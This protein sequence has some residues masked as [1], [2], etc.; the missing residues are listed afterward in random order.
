MLMIEL[1]NME[2]LK[3]MKQNT[4][5]QALLERASGV[6]IMLKQ[7]TTIEEVRELLVQYI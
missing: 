3:F 4:Y 5:F 6:Y 2:S 1:D 7:V